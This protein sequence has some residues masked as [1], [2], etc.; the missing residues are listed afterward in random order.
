MLPQFN[1]SVLN[2]PTFCSASDGSILIDGLN[3]SSTYDLSYND[4]ISNIGPFSITT[5]ASGEVLLG[6]EAGT[7]SSFIISDENC[8]FTVVDPVNLTDPLAPEFAASGF[9]DPSSCGGNDG[10]IILTGLLSN[11]PYSLSYID[12]GVNIGPLNISQM[13]VG[14]YKSAI[15]MRVYTGFRFRPCRLFGKYAKLNHIG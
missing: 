13:L 7:Y 1:N 3:I 15:L 4:G 5:D 2:D 14:K 10:E 11:T 9:T 8:S 6:L 12:D